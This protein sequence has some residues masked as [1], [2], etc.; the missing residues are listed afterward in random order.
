MGAIDHAYLYLI[1]WTDKHKD[2]LIVRYSVIEICDGYTYVVDDPTLLWGSKN[3]YDK[4]F[5]QIKR[6]KLSE[7]TFSNL[8]VAIDTL[9]EKISESQKKLSAEI[10]ELSQIKAEIQ[11][12]KG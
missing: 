12:L 10:R 6:M 2:G 7:D 9:T 4:V 5:S 11:N 1:Y 8:F 3:A